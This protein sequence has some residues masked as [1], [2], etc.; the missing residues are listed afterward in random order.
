MTNSV[1]LCGQVYDYSV[2]SILIRFSTESCYNR[3]VLNQLPTFDAES[4]SAKI[5]M[6]LYGG[7]VFRTKFQLFMLGPNLL[8]SQSPFMVG[9]QDQ[10]LTFDAESKSTKIP[11]FPI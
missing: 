11:K 2:Q 10:L 6:S 3:G 4:K 9:W 5:P 7:G 1:I 8:K